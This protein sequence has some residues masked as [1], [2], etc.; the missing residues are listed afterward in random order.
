M[1]I[2][3]DLRGFNASLQKTGIGWCVFELLN[4]ISKLIPNQ[5]FAFNNITNPNIVEIKNLFNM[6]F[7]NIKINKSIIPDK[8]YQE[9]WQRG[10]ESFRNFDIF[11]SPWQNFYLPK[12]NTKTLTV[13]TIY[14]LTVIIHKNLHHSINQKTEDIIRKNI[15]RCDYIIADSY[16]TKND[17]CQILNFSDK[18]ISV[19]YP[20]VRRIFCSN[21]I[22]SN[23]QIDYPFILFVGTLEPRKN[24]KS[25]IKAFN[26]IKRDKNFN[27]YKLILAGKRGWK[28][29]NIFREIKNS[30]YKND[31]IWLKYVSE[32][33]L[34][35]LY[36]KAKVFVFPSIYEGFG[37]PVME[38]MISKCPVITSNNSSLKEIISNSGI[39]LEDPFNFELIAQRIKEIIYDSELRQ[40]VINQGY[41][42]SKEFLKDYAL[43]H[44]DFYKKIINEN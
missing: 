16:N 31:I 25:L 41:N 21:N 29:E 2:C 5:V 15:K 18:K 28:S 36:K 35:Y 9:L 24:I 32:N 7:S 11:H 26:L 23:L 40:Y 42:R 20:P 33:N 37:M 39:L 6:S 19:I 8:I 12:T 22:K 1:K 34:A 43:Q 3:Y 30:Q 14:D 4:N 17:I 38:A 10:F 13:M 27:N 44:L